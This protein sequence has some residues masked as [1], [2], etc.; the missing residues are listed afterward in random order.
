MEFNFV[1]VLVAALIPTI[2][3]FLYYNPKSLG[4][5]WMNS[6]GKTEEELQ[7]G[8]NM[9][10]VMGVCL[11][12]S[13]FMAFIL[14]VILVTG[15]PPGGMEGESIKNNTFVHGV[16]HGV[17]LALLMVMPVIITN[18]LYERKTWKN[19]FL[20]VGYWVITMGLMSGLLDAW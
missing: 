10:M 13:L 3:G 1:A 6:L 18:G 7:D 11:V 14:K 19:M 15:H 9:P 4:T 20:G 16:I 8:F 17:F 12:M 2:V 5:A